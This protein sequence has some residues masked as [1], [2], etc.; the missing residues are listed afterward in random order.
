ML[1]GLL[2]CDGAEEP[3]RPQGDATPGL[4]AEV[5]RVV[6]L[7]PEGSRFVEAMG[8]SDLLVGT[9]G[10]SAGLPGLG[11]LPVV[12]LET[13][14]RVHPDLVLVPSFPA[15]GD[16]RLQALE[17]AGVDLVEFA[18]HDFEDVFA[19]CRELGRRLVGDVRARRFER[20][21]SR[22]LA[23]IGGASFGAARLR[24]VAV[25][26]L[27]PVELAGGHSFETDLIEIAGGSSV[28]HGGDESRLVAREEL[29]SELEPD[30]VLVVTPRE[31]SPEGR[32]AA[33][34]AI[35]PGTPIEF[36]VVDVKDFWLD[37]PEAAAARLRE[38][39]AAVQ[40][41]R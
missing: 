32:R 12:D 3:A 26:G 22:P 8:A 40:E 17:S 7:V 38:L 6:S 21:L 18:P 39:L 14:G 20:E 29:W 11:G 13:A 31:L 24:I 4:R 10:V 41:T 5:P 27:D 2:A 9:D 1:A 37:E 25:V 35:P 33:R 34:D 28:T 19:L 36:F 16:S 30:L 15:P 23:M